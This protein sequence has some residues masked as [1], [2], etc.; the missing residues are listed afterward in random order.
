MRPNPHICEINTCLFI[1]R[2]SQKYKQALT[3]ATVL[4]EEWQLLARRGFDLVW[5]MGVWQRSSA[6]RQQ[7][8]LNLSLRRDYDN[9]LP[10]WSDEDI[11]RSPYAIYSYNLNPLLGQPSE[12]AQLKLTLNGMDSA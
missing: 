1:R 7:A 12:I 11:N 10:G 9:A 5:L 3:L 2:L 4:D 8:L 6:A